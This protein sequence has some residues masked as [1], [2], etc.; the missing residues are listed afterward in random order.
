VEKLR[1]VIAKNVI[2]KRLII[3]VLNV[4]KTEKNKNQ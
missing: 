4:G 1:D 3:F 2:E